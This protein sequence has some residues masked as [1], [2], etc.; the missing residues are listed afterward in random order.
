LKCSYNIL[1]EIIYYSIHEQQE[2]GLVILKKQYVNGTFF[3]QPTLSSHEKSKGVLHLANNSTSKLG[4]VKDL[5]DKAKISSAN[6]L[7]LTFDLA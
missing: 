6:S 4:L 3:K 5:N 2:I 1:D 7:T